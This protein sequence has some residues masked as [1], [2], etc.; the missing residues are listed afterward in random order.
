MIGRVANMSLPKGPSPVSRVPN[1]ASPSPET[2]QG[3]HG[4]DHLSIIQATPWAGLGGHLVMEAQCFR[5]RLNFCCTSAMTASATRR[6]SSSK[7]SWPWSKSPII[8][9]IKGPAVRLPL[10][11]AALAV[12]GSSVVRSRW[13]HLGQ[14]NV[15]RNIA[16]A[17]ALGVKAPHGHNA[18][19][20][21][22]LAMARAPG[23]WHMHGVD[24]PAE[25]EL[26][27]RS[28]EFAQGQTMKWCRHTPC[29]LG[30]RGAISVKL[31]R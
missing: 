30:E 21:L 23:V 8:S 25:G 5:R 10:C 31:S 6:C 27:E 22:I 15:L 20:A 16:P 14:S 2:L 12:A 29:P 19:M 11:P 28:G 24:A 4:F 9:N 17:V 7:R 1:S 3:A 26:V 18:V 13:C